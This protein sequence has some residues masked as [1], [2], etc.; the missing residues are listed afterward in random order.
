MH[1]TRTIKDDL[2]WVGVNDRRIERFEAQYAVPGGI[3][4]NAYLLLDEKTVL[5][6]TVDYGMSRLFMEWFLIVR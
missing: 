4:Y 2:V 6:D 3:S 5:W 1:C